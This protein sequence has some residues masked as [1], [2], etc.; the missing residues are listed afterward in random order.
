MIEV[1]YCKIN[2]KNF[3]LNVKN[4]IFEEGKSYFIIGPSGS[5]KTTL[6]RAI[7]G[8]EKSD[9]NI[10]RIINN[11][12]ID[13]YKKEYK[14]DLIYLSQELNLWENLSVIEHLNFV[15]SKGKSIKD[16]S[17]SHY[18]L[19]LLNLEDK[20]NQKPQNLSQGEKQRVAIAR[21][22]AAKP[23]FL[24]LDEPFANIDVV[25]ANKFMNII[26]LEQD[27]EKFA[28]ISTTHHFIG[29]DNE[30]NS[31][32][33]LED[34]KIVFNSSYKDLITKRYTSWIEDWKELML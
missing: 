23:K 13:I 12:I 18:Y 19:K 10:K 2:K 28:L 32:I 7:L 29:L 24:F 20:A 11:K 30:Y 27:K 16:I 3:I 1:K 14:N 17:T 6:I 22:L 4:I 25:Q 5:G 21:A 33:V 8:L 15:I 34:G 9:C 26:K 31:I